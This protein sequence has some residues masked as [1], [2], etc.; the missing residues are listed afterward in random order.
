M[1]NISII[2]HVKVLI[3]C[4]HESGNGGLATTN[5]VKGNRLSDIATP[6]VRKRSV[7]CDELPRNW[8]G[9]Q[10]FSETRSI[11]VMVYRSPHLL[12]SHKH[13]F[14]ATGKPIDDVSANLDLYLTTGD[15]SSVD[16]H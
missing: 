15:I 4:G 8:G 9:G 7:S 1:L 11:Y 12:I 2:Y 10:M 13:L 6:Q 16:G 5:A 14:H 3:L